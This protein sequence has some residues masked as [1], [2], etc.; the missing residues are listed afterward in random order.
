MLGGSGHAVKE[1][2]ESLVVTSR[3]TALEI[4]VD[5]TKYMVVSGDQNAGQSHSMKTNNSFFERVEN[6]KVLWKTLTHKNS[7]Q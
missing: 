1:N 5:K 4:N 2:A 3:Q 7:I 6:F